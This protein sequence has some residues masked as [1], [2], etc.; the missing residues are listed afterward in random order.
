MNSHLKKSLSGLL[1]LAVAVITPL[2][3]CVS[4]RVEPRVISATKVAA[5]VGTS[6]Y[7]RQVKEKNPDQLPGV[8]AKFDE[9]VAQLQAFEA[10]ENVDAATLVAIAQQFPI[11]E[12]QSEQAA[13]Y[14]TAATIVL[15]DFAEQIAIE[16][17]AE[18]KPVAAAM[19][20]G[21]QLAKARFQSAPR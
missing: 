17:I 14:V 5:Y 1:L 10:T 8:L 4:G 9:A 3:G 21:I 20:Q 2:T 12:L 11:K 6:E 15:E 7:L 18:L 19:R 16:K 13:I